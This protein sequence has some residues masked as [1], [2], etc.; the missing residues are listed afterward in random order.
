MRGCGAPGNRGPA[1]LSRRP[2]SASFRAEFAFRSG[3]GLL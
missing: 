3:Q 2:T 1:D